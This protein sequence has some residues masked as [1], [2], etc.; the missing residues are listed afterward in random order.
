MRVERLPCAEVAVCHQRTRIACFNQYVQDDETLHAAADH[1]DINR[2]RV[3]DDLPFCPVVLHCYVIESIVTLLRKGVKMGRP[4]EY[5]ERTATALLEAAE[6]IVDKEG[7]D[8]LSVRRVASAIA[9][10]TRAVY[11]LFGSK[12]GL[13]VALGE[14]AFNLLK[15]ALDALPPTSD[16][17]S[18]LVEAG[19][20]VFRR[21]A[22]DH[23]ALLQ[24]GLMHLGVSAELAQQFRGASDRALAG[25]QAR[26]VRLAD[27]GQLGS[28][29]I[30]AAICEFDA[31]CEGLVM[32]ELRG[33]L[34]PGKAERIWQDALR[35]LVVG[36]RS[37]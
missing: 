19:A 18:D 26:V 34:S 20:L 30:A 8:A 37:P 17:T 1:H 3:H 29:D 25:L 21:F 7:L 27:L 9:V 22:L 33:A 5:D 4:R 2:R 35:S 24:I 14:R 36:W 32:L 28:R 23:P 6:R 10:T 31:L 12:D 15:A 13:V 16:P 11:S